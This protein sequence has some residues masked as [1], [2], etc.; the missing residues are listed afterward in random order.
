MPAAGGRLREGLTADAPLYGLCRGGVPLFGSGAVGEGEGVEPHL[1]DHRC[2]AVGAGGERLALNPMASMNDSSVSRISCG[3]RPFSTRTSSAMMPLVMM[4]S[5]SA[6]NHTLPS[7][8]RASTH[9]R[10][11]QP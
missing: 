6:P 2:E 11:W 9:T 1:L 4:A 5:L 3:V 8:M 7:S 10:D